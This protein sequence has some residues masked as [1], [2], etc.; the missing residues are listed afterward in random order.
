MTTPPPQARSLLLL[1]IKDALG[2]AGA[3][4]SQ[5]AP[6]DDAIIAE[7]IEAC[8]DQLRIALRILSG[9]SHV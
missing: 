4:V 9:D 8:R 5:R 3:A 6:S 2:H 7:H 1:L